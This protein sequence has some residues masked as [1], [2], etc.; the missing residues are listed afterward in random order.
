[1]HTPKALTA[2]ALSARLKGGDGEGGEGSHFGG[3]GGRAGLGGGLG[4]GLRALASSEADVF[5]VPD[6]PDEC[7][8]TAGEP[9]LLTYAYA[10]VR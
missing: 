4:A 6:E 3:V 5:C 10:A 8:S 2:T 1:V 9:Y 7:G